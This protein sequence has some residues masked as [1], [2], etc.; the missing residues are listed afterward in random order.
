MQGDGFHKPSVTSA[1][2]SVYSVGSVIYIISNLSLR[3]VI[4]M[5]KRLILIV[6]AAVGITLAG[7]ALFLPQIV[8]QAIAQGMRG[9][10][11]SNQVTAQ[12]EKSPA[13]LLLGG[14]FDKVRLTAR[15]AKPDKIVFSEM[16][17]DLSG[18]RVDM[19]ELVSSRRVVLQEVQAASLSASVSQEELGR[20]LNQTIK[21][22]SNAKV[23]IQNSKVQVAGT[24]SIG[25]I[26]K[27][28]V[29]LEGRVVVDGQKIKMVTERILLNNS[30]VGSLGGSLLADI[31]LVDVKSLP[32]GVTLRSVV[33]DQ[34]KITVYADN[35]QSS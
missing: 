13:F 10:L 21:G 12:V 15:D 18:V 2:P 22:V 26:A 8:S 25:Q 24:F 3:G 19:T 30:P 34:G 33:A 16:Q 11:H 27:M 1:H 32:F 7:L 35:K 29:T 4:P 5:S 6:V 28:T 31:Q 23:T 20:Y 17:A 9:L 14:Q